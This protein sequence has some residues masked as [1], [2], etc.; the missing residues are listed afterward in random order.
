MYAQKQSS[1]ILWMGL[2]LWGLIWGSVQTS[3]QHNDPLLS[4]LKTQAWITTGLSQIPL[5]HPTPLSPPRPQEKPPTIT[6]TEAFWS[7]IA[8]Q[9]YRDGNWEIYWMDNH[10]DNQTRFT[11]HPASDVHPRIN[12]DLTEIVFSSKRDGNWEIYKIKTDG[13]GLQRLT[14]NDTDDAHPAWSP[15]GR[16]IIFAHYTGNQW[17]IYRM[18]ADGSG[19]RQLTYPQ[20]KKDDLFPAWSPNGQ[21]IAWVSRDDQ[22][23]GDLMVM[24]ANGGNPTV[25]RAHLRFLQNPVWSPNGQFIACDA[26]LSGN[27]WNQ[28]VVYRRSD[29]KQWWKDYGHGDLKDAWMGSWSPDGKKLLFSLISYVVRDNRLYISETRIKS[30][31]IRNGYE[32]EIGNTPLDMAPD[33]RQ[34]IDH[35]PP[36]V[37]IEPL[38]QVSPA[39]IPVRWSAVDV[40]PAGVASY[41]VQVREGEGNWGIWLR[42][43]RHTSA[44]YP[45]RGG[46]RYAFRVRARDHAGNLSDWVSTQTTVESLPPHSVFDP[47]PPF[48]RYGSTISWH[49]QDPGGSGIATYN[50]QYKQSGAEG[51]QPWLT[52]TSRTQASFMGEMGKAYYFRVQATD[53]AHNVGPWN[54]TPAATTLYWWGITGTIFDN[55][56]RPIPD[57]SITST[58]SARFGGRSNAAG[59]YY[60]YTT[61]WNQ[62]YQIRWDKPGYGLLP[63]TP[64]SAVEDAHT[65]VVL[66]PPDNVLKNPS[67]EHVNG[68]LGWQGRGVFLPRPSS[69]AHTGTLAQHLGQILFRAGYTRINPPGDALQ[70]QLLFDNRGDRHYLWHDGASIFYYQ[71]IAANGTQGPIKQI[72]LGNAQNV[73]FH[74]AK[75]GTVHVIWK[76]AFT[77]YHYPFYAVRTPDGV[78]QQRKLDVKDNYQTTIDGQGTL[79]ILYVNQRYYQQRRSDGTWTALEQ[80]PFPLGGIRQVAATANGTLF[81]LFQSAQGTSFAKRYPDGRWQTKQRLPGT[82]GTYNAIMRVDSHQALHVLAYKGERAI[83]TRLNPDGSWSEEWFIMPP[84]NYRTQYLFVDKEGGVHILIALNVSGITLLYR[85]GDPEGRWSDVEIQTIPQE[86]VQAIWNVNYLRFAMDGQKRLYMAG[87]QKYVVAGLRDSQGRWDF[88]I[89]SFEGCETYT[90]HSEED[91]P[92]AIAIDPGNDVA[93]MA[94]PAGAPCDIVTTRTISQGGDS[95][96]EQRVTIPTSLREP[97]LSFFYRFH[98]PLPSPATLNVRVN[99]TSLFSTTVSTP[100]WSHQWLDVSAWAGQTVTVTFDITQ[101]PG[102]PST[103]AEIDDVTLG[104]SAYP[105]LWLAPVPP[106]SPARGQSLRLNIPYGNAGDVV[107]SDVAITLTWPV[108]LTLVNLEPP[109]SDHPSAQIW[110]WNVGSLSPDT[111]PAGTLTITARVPELAARQVLSGTLHVAGTSREVVQENNERTLWFF[112]DGHSLYLPMMIANASGENPS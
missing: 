107:A 44:E 92:A 56:H 33:W 70:V 72:S 12:G 60:L 94:W 23:Y 21:E 68:E 38:S 10:G 47:I 108:T 78:W 36:V 42:G 109:P 4:Q 19:Q 111:D 65:D 24:P 3:A 15:D 1:L 96:L 84:S 79:H 63:T 29:G 53:R 105:D 102:A 100:E 51:W 39:P 37:Q 85:Y 81:M 18:N 98:R 58:P 7:Q 25:V 99:H 80:V 104:S 90:P 67:F 73:Q 91:Y 71:H 87:A 110:R 76:D 45:G 43:V 77:N 106:Q 27:N 101:S 88:W 93:Y 61:N 30:V 55:R 89:P 69:H 66:P 35:Q 82:Q 32:Q 8:F 97:T 6:K 22:G 16:Y 54:E 34:A 20:N 59:D 103:W 46:H 62:T 57:A 49:G 112:V 26:D 75:D 31:E 28:V 14:H 83:Y 41:D 64:Y 2:I 11:H 13:T 17:V 9:S 74:V 50:V 86:I 52:E 95:R 5:L 48:K 40:G